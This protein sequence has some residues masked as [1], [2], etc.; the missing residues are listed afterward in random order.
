MCSEAPRG[1]I[2]AKLGTALG[3]ADVITFDNFWRSDEECRFC[4]RSNSSFPV[5]KPSRR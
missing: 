2:C 3:V 4:K 1:R 5:D